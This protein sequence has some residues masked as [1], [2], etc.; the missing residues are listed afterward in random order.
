[1]SLA[2]AIVLSGLRR[3]RG[4]R[5]EV[6]EPEGKLLAFG[7]GD[8]ELRARVEVHDPRAWREF[9]VGS[10]GM[11]EAYIERWWDCDDLVSLT[12]IGAR[13]LP[14]LDGIRRLIAPVKRLIERVPRN[15][16]GAS[17]R[18]IAAH[19][20]LGNELFETFLDDTMTYSCAVFDG[21]D[22]SLREAQEAKL[23]RICRKLELTPGGPLARDRYRLGRPGDPR[24]RAT[25]AAA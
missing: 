2:R 9:L 15:T 10:H 7:P 4:G 13:D 8:A 24:R 12:R 21:P 16:I 23:E 11:G 1:M 18:H 25:T 6:V 22:M 17:R 3:V 19:Y 5:L 20:D 14:R